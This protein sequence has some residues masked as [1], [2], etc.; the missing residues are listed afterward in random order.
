MFLRIIGN[1]R[2]LKRWGGNYYFT[3]DRY[4]LQTCTIYLDLFILYKLVQ[5]TTELYKPVLFTE[6]N[7]EPGEVFWLH[8]SFSWLS[9]LCLKGDE[10]WK[11][12]IC[13]KVNTV[14]LTKFDYNLFCLRMTSPNLNW[15]LCYSYTK[16]PKLAIKILKKW[17]NGFVRFS[18]FF[19]LFK[20]I[21]CVIESIKATS[22]YP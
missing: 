13:L 22:M 2:E 8:T 6:T 18:F 1:N 7:T 16:C 12:I 21:W 5:F 19:R 9:W 11:S 10:K 15:V 17:Q 4:P 14:K 20:L 3:T